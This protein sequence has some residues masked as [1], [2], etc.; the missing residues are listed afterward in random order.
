[1][2]GI[3]TIIA[4]IMLTVITIGLVATAYLY[5][6][7]IVQV[8]PVVSIAAAYCIYDDSA[9]RYN[10]TVTLRNDGTT[11]F[12]LNQLTWLIDGKQIDVGDDNCTSNVTAAG[13][14]TTCVIFESKSGVHN[15]VVI[16]PR[17]QAGGPVTC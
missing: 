13:D 9:G 2:K 8:G 3:S 11:Q 17:N 1:M 16:G 4:A 10:L 15:F 14:T 5:F 12:S 6:S 7:S